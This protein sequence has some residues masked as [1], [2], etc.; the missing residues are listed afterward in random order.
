MDVQQE[1]S[2]LRW[3]L[4]GVL[5]LLLGTLTAI[6]SNDVARLNRLEKKVEENERSDSAR[7]TDVLKSVAT[8]AD[9]ARLDDSIQQLTGILMKRSEK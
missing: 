6:R 8:K 9:I 4:E 5:T 1:P 3:I 7:Y 2:F